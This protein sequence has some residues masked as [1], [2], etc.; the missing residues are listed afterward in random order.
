MNARIKN[1]GVAIIVG[2]FVLSACTVKNTKSITTTA[3]PNNAKIANPASEYC[4]QKGGKL[5]TRQDASAGSAGV[6][7]FPDASECD[8][9]AFYRGECA[10]GSKTSSTSDQDIA[11]SKAVEIVRDELAAQLKVEASSLELVSVESIDWS[12]ACLGLPQTGETCTQTITRGFRIT[13]TSAGQNYIFHT[14]ASAN[15][16]RQDS[17]PA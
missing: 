3:T 4:S 17:G 14:D 12:D 2:M 16:I 8:E 11:Q 6:C 9:W 5:E 1:I 7:V 15:V 10:P 13:F